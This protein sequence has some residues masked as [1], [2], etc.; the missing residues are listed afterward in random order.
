MQ[1]LNKNDMYNYIYNKIF[2]I[3]YLTPF[4]GGFI[5]YYFKSSF[6]VCPL[7][8][9]TEIPCPACGLTRAF[10]EIVHLH[11][12]EALQYNLMIIVL[13]PV[14]IMLI[15]LQLMPLN[16]KNKIFTFLAVNIK[17]INNIL[18]GLFILFLLLGFIRIF[19]KFYHFINFKDITP[20]KTILKFIKNWMH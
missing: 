2:L 1:I 6:T 10:E 20:D 14:L 11:F 17:I 9:L 8:T 16:Y 13:I 19:D 12:I 18:I 3:I 4:V 15:I 5:L 7:M